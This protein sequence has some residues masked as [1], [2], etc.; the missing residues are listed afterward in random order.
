MV[1]DPALV[2]PVGERCPE[3]RKCVS[4]GTYGPVWVV[5]LDAPPST[6]WKKLQGSRTGLRLWWESL[7]RPR[8]A[9]TTSP[10]TSQAPPSSFNTS[11][12]SC[13]P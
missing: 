12:R 8:P 4:A 5:E 1:G 9:R 7:T 2:R 10:S 3:R 6:Q 13:H 11:A